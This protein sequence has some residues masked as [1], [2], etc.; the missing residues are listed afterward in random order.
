MDLKDD[1]ALIRLDR[2]VTTIFEDL[3]S[4]VMPI[5]LGFPLANPAD[6]A[7]VLVAGWGEK[8]DNIPQFSTLRKMWHKSRRKDGG[9]N[10]RSKLNAQL[11][12]ASH[13][14]GSF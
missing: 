4:V 8:K 9:R 13:L 7:E 6:A 14:S 11:F 10:C 1:I 3:T 12:T 2:A 5:C